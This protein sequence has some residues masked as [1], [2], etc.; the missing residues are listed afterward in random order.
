[1]DRLVTYFQQ[2]RSDASKI[3][4]QFQELFFQCWI[5]SPKDFAK[6]FRAPDDCS[7]CKGV[8]SGIRISNVDPDEFEMKYAYDGQVVIVTDATNNWTATE[9]FNFWY[10]KQLYENEDPKKRTR[11]CQ[12]FPYKTSFK[13]IF[14]AFKMERD[15]VEYKSSTEPWYFGWSNCK[16]H[17][18]SKLRQHYD[19]PYFLPKSSELNA[20]DWIFMGGRGLGAHMHLDDVSLPSWQAQLKGRKEWMLAPPPECIFKCSSFSVTVNPGE[21]SE[22]I[23]SYQTIANKFSFPVVLDTNKWFH[24]TNVLSDDVSITIG[25]E[26]D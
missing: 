12:F 14:E 1:M 6:I 5:A 16:E 8:K 9:V 13:S 15:R 4:L 22:S 19:R 24:K 11:D 2:K 23:R 20:I 17:I 10:F 18:A 3:D 26:Y 25:A 21:I 7:F